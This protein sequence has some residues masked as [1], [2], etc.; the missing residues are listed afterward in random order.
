MWRSKDTPVVRLQKVLFCVGLWVF[1]FCL[2]LWPCERTT[3]EVLKPEVCDPKNLCIK[4]RLEGRWKPEEERLDQMRC[5]PRSRNT[6]SNTLPR[7]KECAEL[8]EQEGE[9]RNQCAFTYSGRKGQV[10]GAREN[11]KAYMRAVFPQSPQHPP[12]AEPH[13]EQALA[14]CV[15]AEWKLNRSSNSRFGRPSRHLGRSARDHSNSGNRNKQTKNNKSRQ[16]F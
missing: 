4:S 14:K 15:L 16:N 11:L 5:C 8:K 6:H 3:R 10:A 13:A 1:G 2:E 12:R 9:Q 7:K